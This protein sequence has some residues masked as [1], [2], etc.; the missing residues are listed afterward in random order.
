MWYVLGATGFA[1][2]G[3]GN[4]TVK[5]GTLANRRTSASAIPGV[6]RS[7]APGNAS[8]P[9]AP[10][11]PL[12]RNCRLDIRLFVMGCLFSLQKQQKPTTENTV[13]GCATGSAR[14]S[15]SAH[16]KEAGFLASTIRAWLSFFDSYPS[17][18]ACPSEAD[19]LVY[20]S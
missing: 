12:I 1:L 19:G 17:T 14:L 18:S 7:R 20:L 9:P 4:A 8:I 16:L 6:A 15:L 10:A 13:V 5:R 3:I 2:A 11:A